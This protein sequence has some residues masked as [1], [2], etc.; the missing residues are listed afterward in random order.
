MIPVANF[1]V[2]SLLLRA[3]A[4]W[5]P[6]LAKIAVAAALLTAFILVSVKA[7][8]ERAS[9]EKEIRDSGA[10][11]VRLFWYSPPDGVPNNLADFAG[12][13]AIT[14]SVMGA[15]CLDE[16]EQ[17]TPVI[18]LDAQTIRTL[19]MKEETP[20]LF[21]REKAPAEQLAVMRLGNATVHAAVESKEILRKALPYDR[22]LLVC[23]NTGDSKAQSHCAALILGAE[24]DARTIRAKSSMLAAIAP[25]GVIVKDGTELLEK[26]DTLVARQ[27]ALQGRIALGIA[28]FIAL[29]FGAIAELEFGAKSR[30]S[31]ILMQLGAKPVLLAVMELVEPVAILALSLLISLKFSAPAGFEFTH[32]EWRYLAFAGLGVLAVLFVNQW[33]MLSRQIGLL[34]K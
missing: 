2:R 17:G 22:A 30:T 31:A 13:D 14:Y 28:L 11:V 27:R 4:N 25:K 7:A 24:S 15:R 19:G 8:H 29:V 23:N 16:K 32:D 33:R 5:R 10:D 1:F 20:V 34:L 18:L 9:L 6:I 26:L 12:A 3:K 21:V